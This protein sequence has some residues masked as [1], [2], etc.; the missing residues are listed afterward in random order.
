MTPY[1]STMDVIIP[2]IGYELH[3]NWESELN[4]HREYIPKN[5]WYIKSFGDEAIIKRKLRISEI[6]HLNE[7]Q[8]KTIMQL[9]A[10]LTIRSIENI[11]EGIEVEYIPEKSIIEITIKLPYEELELNDPDRDIKIEEAAKIGEKIGKKLLEF[12]EMLKQKIKT[13]KFKKILKSKKIKITKTEEE[14]AWE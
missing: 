12:D 13:L 9:T 2:A 1:Q 8:L 6:K 4:K 5:Y 11:T 3:R 7:Y 10:N 14:N